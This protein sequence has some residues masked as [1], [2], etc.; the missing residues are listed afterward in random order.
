MSSTRSTCPTG[1]RG[2]SEPCTST[3]SPAEIA[4]AAFELVLVAWTVPKCEASRRWASWHRRGE[5]SACDP[6][7]EIDLEAAQPLR[8]TAAESVELV[9]RDVTKPGHP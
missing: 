5:T 1:V 2:S 9:P 7:H 3:P 8:Q 4:N 6:D